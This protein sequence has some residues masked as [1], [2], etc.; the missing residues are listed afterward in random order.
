MTAPS[1][2]AI[3]S[4]FHADS[5]QRRRTVHATA[6]EFAVRSTPPIRKHSTTYGRLVRDVEAHFDQWTDKENPIVVWL[7]AS[8]TP[9]ATPRPS[10]PSPRPAL[11]VTN[12]ALATDEQVQV[13]GTGPTAWAFRRGDALVRTPRVGE[14]GYLPPDDDGH[15]GPAQVR[16]LS[17]ATLAANLSLTYACT[18]RTKNDDGKWVQ[19][20]TLF[21]RSSAQTLVDAVDQLRGVRTLRGVVHTPTVRRD[22]SI[23]DVPGYDAASGLLYLPEAGLTVPKV[24]AHP[25]AGELAVAVDGVL[26]VLAGF[27]FLSDN[28]RANYLGALLTPLLRSICPPPYKLLAVG[29]P[30]PGSGKTLL[31][32]ILRTLFG[33]VFR[34]EMP[35]DDAELR[36]SITAILDVT[37]APVV[38][39]DNLTGVLRS[40]TFAGLLTGARWDD[41]RL[42]STAMVSRPNDRLWV[43]TGNNLA[44]GGDLARRTVHV[45]IDPGMPDPHRRTDFDITDLESY[46]QDNR[47]DLLW[48][49]LTMVRAWIVAGR[50]TRGRR[51]SDGY[52]AWVEAVDG[53]LGVARIPGRFDDP[54]AAPEPVGH[55]DDEW[56]DLLRAIH[57][58]Q[59][60]RSWTAA[61]LLARVNP[62]SLG[63]DVARPIPIDALPQELADKLARTTGGPTSLARP[64]GMWLRNR[65]GRWAGGLT[66]RSVGKDRKDKALWRIETPRAPEVQL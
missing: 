64:L 61:E 38:H 13:L 36:K 21:P 4:Q 58:D 30:Q 44:I 46:V 51:G 18:R 60:D 32:T 20:R 49:L 26:D 59:G 8:D 24:S 47:G 7:P 2:E 57:A 22:G 25:D 62:G 29:A 35:G 16:P 10:E 9:A 63:L 37:T 66:V 27:P 5:E 12:D 14:E 39:F 1:F 41:R 53:I 48:C 3:V 50:P 40:S 65:A 54:G 31:A 34:S 23:L 17:G 43:V 19:T 45:T 55:D 56:A 15:D 33:G 42:G 6:A 11:D 28:D 52:A